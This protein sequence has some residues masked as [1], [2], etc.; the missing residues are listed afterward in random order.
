VAKRNT[1]PV[2]DV[3]FAVNSFCKQSGDDDK[4]I[5][6]ALRDGSTGLL[7]TILHRTGNYVG[8]GYLNVTKNPATGET[9]IPDESRKFFYI[10]PNLKADYA[11]REA[12]HDKTVASIDRRLKVG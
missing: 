2:A 6:A 3:L 7:D 8:F 9:V 4:G 10:A 5:S 1:V 12:E 11:R